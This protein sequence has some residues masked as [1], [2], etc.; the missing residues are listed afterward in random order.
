MKA[1][2]EERKAGWMALE[3]KVR[4]RIKDFISLDLTIYYI[5]ASIQK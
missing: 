4:K 2:T 1:R 5:I 3:K